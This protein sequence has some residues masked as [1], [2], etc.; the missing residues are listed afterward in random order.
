MVFN[1]DLAQFKTLFETQHLKPDNLRPGNPRPQI[2]GQNDH[3]FGCFLVVSW[4]TLIPRPQIA[5]TDV[6]SQKESQSGP[7]PKRLT[8]S[9]SRDDP[10][11]FS[12]LIL[13]FRRISDPSQLTKFNDNLAT[14]CG[15]HGFL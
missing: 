6:G 7:R 9:G 15:L 3:V 5:R 14:A 10:S 8:S 2:G 11:N 1:R 4:P 12:E 13:E